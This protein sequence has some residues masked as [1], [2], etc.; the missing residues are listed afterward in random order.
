MFLSATIRRVLSIVTMSF[1][2]LDVDSVY[3]RH[4]EVGV[5]PAASV[6]SCRDQRLLFM[7]NCPSRP[8]PPRCTVRRLSS[9]SLFCS[10]LGSNR[11]LD[12]RTAMHRIQARRRPPSASGCSTPSH[13]IYDS[14][15]RTRL[16]TRLL[17]TRSVVS[18]AALVHDTIT[19]HRLDVLMMTETWVTSDAP[20]AVKLDVA[21][22][23]YQVNHQPRGSSILLTSAAGALLQST[24]TPSKCDHS[25]SV[26][27]QRSRCRR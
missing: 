5:A 4:A 26:S 6:Y 25:T 23:H 12:R 2:L 9:S 17:N 18:K 14:V 16:S 27:R 15:L 3:D 10:S 8:P 19:D 13:T 21:P 20:D 24:A 1:I 7:C 22:P 11:T